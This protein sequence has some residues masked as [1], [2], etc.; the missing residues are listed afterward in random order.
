M[1]DLTLFGLLTGIISGF[2]GVGG[3]MVLIPMLLFTGYVMK[4]AVAI[5]IMQMVFS[6][7]YGSFLNYKKNNA[8]LKDGL[9]IGIGGFVGGLQN[10]FIHSFV[11]NESLQMLFI[12]I[13]IFSIYRLTISSPHG[14]ESKKFHSTPLLFILGFIIGMIAM[15]IGVGGAVMLTPILVGYLFYNLKDATSLGLFFVIFSSVAGFLSL[16]FAGEM[17]YTEGAIVGVA[18]LIG[19][20]FGVK[21][22]HL[23][24]IKNYKYFILTLNVSILLF[25]VYK[26]FL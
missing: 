21:L 24:N 3:G 11:S 4:D 20:Y 8:I 14:D 7:I 12:A 19:V 5:S 26:T 2:F 1:F 25:M 18:S 17:L 16:S 10:S 9:V 22:K 23:V 6:S 13:V 15:S